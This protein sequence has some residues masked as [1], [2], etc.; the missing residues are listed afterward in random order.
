[1]G[2]HYAA[3]SWPGSAAFELFFISD[4]RDA[5]GAEKPWD[6]DAPEPRP[7]HIAEALLDVYVGLKIHALESESF[8]ATCLCFQLC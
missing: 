6:V 2:R 3:E 4:T 7:G 1:M 8:A 5:C